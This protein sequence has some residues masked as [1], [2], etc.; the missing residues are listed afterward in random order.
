[1][2]T[3]AGVLALVY[4]FVLVVLQLQDYALLVGSLGL[5]LVLAVVMYLSRNINWYSPAE[6]PAGSLAAGEAS[7]AAAS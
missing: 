5:V 7:G 4:G 3:T 6:E 1:Y 2:M